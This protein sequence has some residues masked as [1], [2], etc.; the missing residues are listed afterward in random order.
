MNNIDLQAFVSTWC[1]D[2][3]D[4]QI[5]KNRA[6]PLLFARTLYSGKSII[7]I[8]KQDVFDIIRYSEDM[9]GYEI[10]VLMPSIILGLLKYDDVHLREM[11]GFIALT[12]DMED[13][14]GYTN[15]MKTILTV[16]DGTQKDEAVFMLINACNQLIVSYASEDESGDFV[17]KLCIIKKYAIEYDFNDMFQGSQ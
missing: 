7:S 8:N 1:S 10:G 3:Y 4:S 12:P 5:P 6:S 14:E 11:F 9:T 16:S 17:R 13:I 2:R 15:A